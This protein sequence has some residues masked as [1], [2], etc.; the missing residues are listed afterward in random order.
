MSYKWD[1]EEYQASSSNQKKWGEELLSKIDFKGY[2]KVLDISCGDGKI[3]AYIAQK[4]PQGFVVGIDSSEDMINL[5]KRN[6]PSNTHSNLAF[7]VKDAREIDFEEGFDIVFSNACLHWIVDH[8]PVLEKIKRTLKP[9]G[10]IFLQ[11]GGKGNAAEVIRTLETIIRS[12]KWSKFFNNFSFPYGF[13]STEEY[14]KW[15]KIVGFKIKRVE[16]IKKD[17]V[18]ENK[19]RFASWIRSTWLPY[20]QRV[21]EHLRENF[22]GE[23]VEEYIKKYPPDSN[24]FIHVQMVRLEVEAE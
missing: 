5:A 15:L 20:T 19:K 16:L 22:I 23:V 10:K 6:F 2:E 11:M 7:I 18:H 12:E 17:M 21:L 9:S 14:E 13:Y 24:G 4:V 1:A 3:T 8:L